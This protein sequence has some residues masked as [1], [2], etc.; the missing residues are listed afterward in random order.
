MRVCLHLRRF[1][2]ACPRF[3][4]GGIDPNRTNTNARTFSGWWHASR[5]HR[6]GHKASWWLT[7]K[8]SGRPEG[9]G[10]SC[11]NG[12]IS[13]LR[14][15]GRQLSKWRHRREPT[16]DG[17]LQLNP[18]GHPESEGQRPSINI[19]RTRRL[20]PA[21]CPELRVDKAAT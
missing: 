2:G 19:S 21:E 6:C 16:R 11:A 7:P 10:R 17:E 4:D 12:T 15:A 5:H 18:S 1:F 8:K 9:G 20:A 3:A 14:T 13:A